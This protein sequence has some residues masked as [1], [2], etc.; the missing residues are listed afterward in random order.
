MAG[1]SFID[2]MR[3]ER[4][5]QP[6]YRP[7]ARTL[8]HTKE[9]SWRVSSRWVGRGLIALLVLLA[10]AI[11]ILLFW[12]PQFRVEE[13]IISGTERISSAAVSDAIK[14]LLKGLRGWVAPADA[15]LVAPSDKIEQIILD[16]F[17]GV[18]SVT[19]HKELPNALKI[20][21]TERKPLAIWSAAGQFFF[22]DE[23]GIAFDEI[24]RSESRDVS[25]PVVVD[26]RQRA[27]EEGDR[28]LTEDTL[29]FVRDV[30]AGITR[31]AGVGINF[32]VAPSRLAPDMTLVTSEGWKIQFDTSQPASLQIATLSEVLKTQV[33]DPNALEYIDLRISGRVFVK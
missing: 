6:H 29:R 18:A 28:V 8:L 7:H 5:R 20:T 11:Y 9:R 15:L 2:G 17:E 16:S 32:F 33:R 13:P 21:V 12:S 26:D 25:L 4:R 30:F 10:A 23:R 24:V 3:P 1:S 19:V 31:E 22:V 14:P 27:T